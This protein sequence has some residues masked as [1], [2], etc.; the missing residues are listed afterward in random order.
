VSSA[1][2]VIPELAP[3]ATLELRK[4]IVAFLLAHPGCTMAELVDG[5]PQCAG[6]FAVGSAYSNL[7]LW[8]GVS[9]EAVQA[10]SALERGRH[11]RFEATTIHPYGQAGRDLNLPYAMKLEDHES[12]HWLPVLL[13]AN[14]KVR[15]SA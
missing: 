11:I 14:R 9:M 4:S 1:A 7:I 5:V 13:H 10:L 15:S 3:A 2:G 8:R 12:P 6:P